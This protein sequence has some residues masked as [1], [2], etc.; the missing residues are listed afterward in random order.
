MA[1][2]AV[3]STARVT[4]IVPQF[5]VDDLERAIGYYCDKLGFE[6]DFKYEDFYAAVK[7]D[8]FAIHLKC[9]PKSRADREYRKQNEHLDAYISVAGIRDLFREMEMSG[10]RVMGPLEQRPWACVDFYVGDPDGNVL[11]FSERNG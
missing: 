1:T 3:H 9:A 5:L 11:C 6:L 2:K 10:A 7:R 4:G 8:G